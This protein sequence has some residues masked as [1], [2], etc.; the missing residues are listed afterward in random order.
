[1]QVVERPGLTLNGL[2]GWARATAPGET[3]ALAEALVWSARCSQC[4]DTDATRALP[5]QPARRVSETATF[6]FRCGAEAIAIELRDL[7][8]PDELDALAGQIGDRALPLAFA[9][10]GPYLVDPR[11]APRRTPERHPDG[12]RP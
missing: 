12:P 5:G 2:A 4:G 10:V 6:C 9:R 7:A 3:I 8:D 11:P 1:M